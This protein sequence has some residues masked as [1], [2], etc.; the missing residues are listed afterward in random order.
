LV[1]V[2]DYDSDQVVHSAA[3]WVIVVFLA[4]RVYPIEKGRMGPINWYLMR[5]QTILVQS[6]LWWC[7]SIYIVNSRRY[8]RARVCN[9]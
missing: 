9:R 6:K 1:L 2:V 4:V 7:T 3:H 8:V 5:F